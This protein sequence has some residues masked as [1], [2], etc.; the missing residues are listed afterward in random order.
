MRDPLHAWH[1]ALTDAS[2]LIRG[3]VAAEVSCQADALSAK[4]YEHMLSDAEAATM[5]DH[6]LVNQRLHASMARWLKQLFCSDTPVEA[7]KAAQRKT[8]EVHARIGVPIE[9]VADGARVL[10]RGLAH[11]LAQGDLP[12]E[13]L[14]DAIRYVYEMI[15]LA[16]DAMNAAY[17]S[18]AHR[19]ARSDE[20]Y[21][22]FFLSQ[23]MK[24]E[25][26]RQKS[27]LL[28]WAHQI[29]VRYYWDVQADTAPVAALGLSNSQFGLWLDHKASMLF[30]G[31][32]EIGRIQHTVATIETELLPRL[33]A[34][35][36]S[37]EVAREVIGS[38]NHHIE[39][40]KLLLGSM[41]DRFI[42]VEDGRDSVTRLLNRR[43]VAS[44]TRHE[45]MLAQRN[46]TVF[47]LLMVDID[48]FTP[49]RQALG[50]EPGDL[51]LSQVAEILLDSVRAG[52]FVFRIGD[53]QFLVL[54]VD[55]A[56]H[57]V[58]SVADGLRQRIEST[59][60]RTGSQATA[61]VTVSVGVALYDGHPDYQRLFDRSEEALRAAK[62]A[63]RNRCALAD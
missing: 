57:S 49:L 1:L 26:E 28:E 30:D 44:V 5:L 53:D 14:A 50:M 35:R 7:K 47:A 45:I 34:A 32:A 23:D 52:D 36:G 19:M 24:A 63:G 10:K 20:A 8:G 61:S 37:H 46:G 40:I 15:D 4:F 29:L 21:R 13:H 55:A 60:L 56:A 43:Y 54:L 27:Q 48:Q 6:A 59:A 3:R 2:D 51:I 62:A 42:E 41:F 9:M 12:R 17:A 16:I 33:N 31:A 58:L 18:S 25:R 11:G 22:L 39:D 38:I